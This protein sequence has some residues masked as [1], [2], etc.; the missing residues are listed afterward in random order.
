M[1]PYER[2]FDAGERQAFKDRGLHIR[3][4]K[5]AEILPL[6]Y[7]EGWWDGYT[8]RSLTWLLSRE[9]QPFWAERESE[10]A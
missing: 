2:G 9:A 6:S 8:P 10:F 3:R 5:P 1:T 4:Q 7:G